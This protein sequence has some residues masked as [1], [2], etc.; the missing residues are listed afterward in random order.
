[1][2]T[3]DN[4]KNLRKK[5]CVSQSQLAREIGIT[6]SMISCYERGTRE[7]SYSTVKK[8]IEL[9]KKNKINLNFDDIRVI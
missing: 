1:M 2:T 7:P 9:A 5:L 3:A 8:L 4:I 6:P